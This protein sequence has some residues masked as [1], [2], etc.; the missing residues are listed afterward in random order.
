MTV[1][2]EGTTF[3]FEKKYKFMRLF[4]FLPKIPDC[5]G[6]ENSPRRKR[7]RRGSSGDWT[8]GLWWCRRTSTGPRDPEPHTRCSGSR[9]PRW[10]SVGAEGG[11]DEEG[12]EPR[13]PDKEVQTTVL[14]IIFRWSV[15]QTLIYYA[16]SKTL[17]TAEPF[18]IWAGFCDASE[19]KSVAGER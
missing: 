6:T 19:F 11:E 13:Q 10:C 8:W 17:I 16:R 3:F 18:L 12:A 14:L 7:W 15:S 1:S 9:V 2:E 4:F 5:S